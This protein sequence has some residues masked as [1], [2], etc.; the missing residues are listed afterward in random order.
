MNPDHP[1]CFVM[2]P[3]GKKKD[4][5]GRSVDFDK[6]YERL[7]VPAVVAAGMEPVRADDGRGGG[8]LQKETFERLTLCEVAVAD[9]TTAGTGVFYLMGMR[10]AVRPGATVPIIADKCAQIAFDADQLQAVRYRI[11]AQG[12]PENEARYRALLT[13]RLNAARQ[14]GTDSPVFKVLPEFPRVEAESFRERLGRENELRTRLAAA[15]HTGGDAVRE[16]EGEIGDL[17]QAEA[18]TVIDLFLSYRAVNWWN[19]MIEMVSRIPPAIARTVLVQEQ[20]GLALYRAGRGEEA[21]AVLRGL[22]SRRGPCSEVYGLLGRVMKNRWEEALNAGDPAAAKEFLERAAD[23]YL[24][25]FE[26]DWR[27]AY[28][29]VNAVTLMEIKE[30]PDPRRREILPVVHYALEQ[31]IRSG[32]A[33]YWDYASL[34]ELM[35]LSKNEAKGI[36]ALGRCLAWVRAPWEP[37]TTAR[38][39]RLIREARQRREVEIPSWVERAEAELLQAADRGTARP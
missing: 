36:D 13:E 3:L 20:L 17:G 7:V 21:E 33:D 29:G 24:K 18:G 23:A 19:E 1:L 11:S 28:P 39:L 5:V 35:V 30:P 22:L 32:A 38:N 8:I 27:D 37:R 2:M 31:R 12:L 34:L 14:G 25:G 6:V 26:A 16:L 4:A 10:H 9:L 15:R